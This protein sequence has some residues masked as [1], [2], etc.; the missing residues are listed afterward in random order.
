MKTTGAV[1][2]EILEAYGNRFGQWVRISEIA[3]TAGLTRD[4][5]LPAILELMEDEDFRAEPEPFG[6]RI[7]AVEREYAPVIGGE[8]RHLIMW[9]E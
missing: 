8:A 2:T 3:Q 7:T 6:H 4:E 1:I 9:S 5:I